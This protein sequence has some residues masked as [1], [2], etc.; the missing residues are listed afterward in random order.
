MRS[1]EASRKSA[2]DRIPK[3]EAIS[4]IIVKLSV[5]KGTLLSTE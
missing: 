5:K 2:R 4:V 1:T 3:G